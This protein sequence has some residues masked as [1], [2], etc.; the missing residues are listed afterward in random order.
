MI[1]LNEFRKRVY[2]QSGEDGLIEKLFKH[3]GINAPTYVEIGGGDGKHLSNT[4]LLW[5][6]GS[7]G[8][9]IEGNAS[10]FAQLTQN[11][12]G[13]YLVN[14]YIDCEEN[15]TMDYWLSASPLPTDFDLLSLDIDG[16]DLWVWKSM[17]KYT[18]KAV[19]VE[20]NYS[21]S[22]S[23]TIAYDPAHRFNDTN[24]YGAS[25]SALIKLGKQKGYELVGWT[26]IHNL[27]FLRKDLCDGIHTHDGK[28]IQT[29]GGWPKSNRTMQ[30]Y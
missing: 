13:D 11:R 25:A 29:G 20:Y 24:Y 16:N 26:D 12:K 19:L 30:P 9:L 2:S 5:E 17:E 10:E 23:V 6:R 7:T 28:W 18:P 14:Q 22:E 8:V 27:L 21:F 3:L 15:N 4:R 1:N